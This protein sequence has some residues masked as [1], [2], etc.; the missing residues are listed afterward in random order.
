MDIRIYAGGVSPVMKKILLILLGLFTTVA[1]G[2]SSQRSNIATIGNNGNFLLTI[3]NAKVYV[4]T[5]NAQLQCNSYLSVFSDPGLTQSVAMPITASATGFYSY[6]IANG[7]QLVE[8]VCTIFN[9]CSSVGL[10]I[11]TYG[12]V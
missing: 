4:C 1:Y 10:T 12:T 2:Q 9:Q 11:G 5:Y 7:T 6:Y 8:K 3:P